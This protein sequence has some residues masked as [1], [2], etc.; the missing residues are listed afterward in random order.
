M[1]EPERAGLVTEG[2][3]V[4][5]RGL[6]FLAAGRDPVGSAAPGSM[7]QASCR[8]TR[9]PGGRQASRQRSCNRPTLVGEP[10]GCPRLNNHPCLLLGAQQ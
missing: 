3:G 7:A 6:P 4:R 1:P 10:F 2:R 5:E 9:S 8:M